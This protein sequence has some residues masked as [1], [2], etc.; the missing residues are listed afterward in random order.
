MNPSPMVK[1]SQEMGNSKDLGTY[2]SGLIERALKEVRNNVS[3]Q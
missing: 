2:L 3:V 1:L